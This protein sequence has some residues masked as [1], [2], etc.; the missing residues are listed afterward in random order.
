MTAFLNKL[1]TLA[2]DTVFPKICVIC[3]KDGY[4]VCPECLTQTAL[5]SGFYCPFCRK[6]VPS[7]ESPECTPYC[8]TQSKIR[9]VFSLSEYSN[10]SVKE[11]IHQF[12]FNGVREIG[13][14][15]GAELAEKLSRSG[16]D[17]EENFI[18]IPIPLHKKSMRRRGFN[19]S[20]ILARTIS[21]K[22]SVPLLTGVLVKTKTT[23]HQTETKNRHERLENLV[24][25]FEIT[26][27]EEVSGKNI[28]LVDDIITT[29]A[30]LTECAKVL[31]RSG[32]KNIYGVA[33]A[34]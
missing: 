22:L 6:R 13:E 26:D 15:F 27:K 33:I 24:G 16:A 12:K 5:Y 1:K 3:K 25:A 11:L 32:A 21:E 18:I 4:F 17:F 28:I 30:T 29:G 31:K 34:R 7:S 23:P 9:A 19:Q 2:L 8:R 10:P 14:T 20:E